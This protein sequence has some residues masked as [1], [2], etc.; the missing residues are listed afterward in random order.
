[1]ASHI[2]KLFGRSPIRPVEEH[3]ARAQGC[4][5]RLGEFLDAALA[6]D[7]DRAE[8]IRA[9]IAEDEREADAMKRDIRARLPR[10]LLLPFARSDLVGLLGAQDRLANRCKDVAGVMLARRM[11]PPEAL[12]E[13]FREYFR[14]ALAAS[15]Q[16]RKAV[17]EMD[18]LLETGFGGKAAD[19]VERLVAELDGMER[20]GDAGQ[21]ALRA[22]LR[23]HEDGIGPV[24]AVFLYRIIDL[25]G[26][27]TAVSRKVGARLLQLM[28]R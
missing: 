3:M 8:A 7:W 17:N 22:A 18:E 26:D 6:R 23:E 14:T 11:A 21:M 12:A 24:D 2:G 28:A 1:M 19:F 25:I 4:V 20:A 9:R 16:A 5:A 27:I 10:S 13:P 15:A